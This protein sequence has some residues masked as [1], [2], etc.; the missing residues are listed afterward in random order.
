MQ[1]EVNFREVEGVEEAN[2]VDMR[3]WKFIT[4]DGGKYIFARRVKPLVD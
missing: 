1:Q 4:H 2:T 3:V